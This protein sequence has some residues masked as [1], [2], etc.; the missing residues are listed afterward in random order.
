M[1]NFLREYVHDHKENSACTWDNTDLT[2]LALS[3]LASVVPPHMC[4]KQSHALSSTNTGFSVLC[5]RFDPP[6]LCTRS[7]LVH[8]GCFGVAVL[9]CV[10]RR[11]PTGTYKNGTLEALF[12]ALRQRRVSPRLSSHALCQLIAFLAALCR[13]T[14]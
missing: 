2:R 11:G 5:V 12:A 14:R 7:E 10:S 13:R 8:R 3:R 1:R 4:T 9:T 6:P